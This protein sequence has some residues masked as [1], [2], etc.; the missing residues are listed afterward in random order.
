M[1]ARGKHKRSFPL[2]SVSLAIL[3]EL[4]RY[5]GISVTANT[6]SKAGDPAAIIYLKITYAGAS[7][8]NVPVSR[9]IMDAPPHEAI[10][11]NP[12]LAD[13]LHSQGSH[14][15]PMR[16]SRRRMR[17]ERRS[18]TPTHAHGREAAQGWRS[19]P[20]S[21]ISTPSL[22]TTWPFGIARL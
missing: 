12:D 9:I 14:A 18:C 2:P 11:R 20:I 17:G 21:T 1:V 7:A 15:S 22:P 19:K 8:D 10:L 13:D 4:S 6:N 16:A 5:D 3:F